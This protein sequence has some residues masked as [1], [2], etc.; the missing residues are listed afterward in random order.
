[1]SGLEIFLTVLSVL[2]SICAI[3]FGYAAFSRN[4][5]KD[6]SDEGK[7]TG[8]MLTEL[9]YIK[10]NTDSIM[11]KQ[12]KQDEQHLAVVERLASVEQ[13]TK[14]AHKRIDRLEQKGSNE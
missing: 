12:E 4:R 8:V 5:K 9:G 3:I 7:N 14:Q 1:M 6:T 2:A 11:R 10:S 13:S